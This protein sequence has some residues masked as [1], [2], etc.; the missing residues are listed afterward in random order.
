MD[1]K[2][3]LSSFSANP[4]Q[5]LKTVLIFSAVLLVMW[6]LM[7][8]QMETG[9]SPVN[10]PDTVTQ[11]KADSLRSVLSESD[12]GRYASD[13][14]SENIFMNAFTTF[15]ILITILGVVWLWSRAKPQ[16]KNKKEFTELG[17]QL[18]GQNAQLKI[19]EIN[20]EVWVMGV[21]AHS[22]NLLH[23][24]EKEEWTSK[25]DTAPSSEKSSFYQIL[26]GKQKQ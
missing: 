26:K 16:T 1:L 23:R 2:Q 20:N 5:V 7:V 17:S 24:Y 21:T 15:L 10:T 22:V 18:L 8:S 25:P 9:N 19:I 3:F 13:E 14:R 11:S 4:K 12:R 6:L